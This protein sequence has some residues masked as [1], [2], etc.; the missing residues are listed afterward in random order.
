MVATGLLL[1]DKCEGLISVIYFRDMPF[2]S[3]RNIRCYRIE[4]CLVHCYF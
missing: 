4:Y 2:Q 1:V 3:N